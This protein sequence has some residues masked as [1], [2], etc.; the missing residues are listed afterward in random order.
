[1]EDDAAVTA[2]GL[3]GEVLEE[4]LPASRSKGMLPSVTSAIA[5]R[6]T[7]P[8]RGRPPLSGRCTGLVAAADVGGENGEDPGDRFDE[9]IATDLSGTYHCCRAALRHLAAGPETP[10]EWWAGEAAG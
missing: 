5:P 6:S 10:M 9:P 8:S 7:M 4:R 3:V 2:F 1:V